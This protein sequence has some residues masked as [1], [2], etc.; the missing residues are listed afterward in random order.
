MSVGMSGLLM[1][2]CRNP[3]PSCFRGHR[4]LLIGQLQCAATLRH[5]SLLFDP[6]L[7]PV[8]A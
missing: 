7:L 2:I 8:W 4:H 1:V 3:P 5:F 6:D